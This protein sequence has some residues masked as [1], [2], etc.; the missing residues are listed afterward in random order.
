MVLGPRRMAASKFAHFVPPN[1]TD[2]PGSWP[3]WRAAILRVMHPSQP[4]FSHAIALGIAA[5][6]ADL[7][8]HGWRLASNYWAPMTAILVLRRG[9]RETMT[10]GAL[11]M[12]GTLLGA[13]AAILISAWLQHSPQ[14]LVRGGAIAFAVLGISRLPRQFRR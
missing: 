1:T 4:E 6:A 7:A 8:A 12:A 3:E 9:P 11:R 5:G 2:P 13:G 14:T 10:R